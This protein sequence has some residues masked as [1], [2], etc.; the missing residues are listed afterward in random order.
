MHENAHQRRVLE[1]V[2][3]I[4]G[5]ERMAIVHQMTDVR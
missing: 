1:H 5:M 4:A 3:E 2:G